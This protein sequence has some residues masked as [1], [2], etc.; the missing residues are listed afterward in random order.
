MPSE[1]FRLNNDD[2]L[3]VLGTTDGLRPIELGKLDFSPKSYRVLIEKGATPEVKFEAANTIDRV[4][5]CG[6]NLAREVMK[7]IPQTLSV[8]LYKQQAK[9]L[10]KELSKAM[11]KARIIEG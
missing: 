9:R 4:T 8:P 10:V 3:V 7:N 11:V 6:L 2:R 1:D 5:S